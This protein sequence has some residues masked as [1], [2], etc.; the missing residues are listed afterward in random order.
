[1]KQDF[2]TEELQAE[3]ERSLGFRLKSLTRL[4]GA[5]A[6][7]FKAVRETDGYAF[8]VKCSPTSRKEAFEGLV[9]HLEELKG[10]KA[11]R[12]VFERETPATFRGYNVICLSW[13]QGKR[14]FPDQLSFEELIRFLD[15]YVAFS[16]AMQKTSRI[17]PCEP[18][19][20][21][22]TRSLEACHGIFGGWLRRILEE[23]LPESEVSYRKGR[24]SVV[25]GDFHHGN[26]LFAGGSVSGFFDL[27][28]FCFG[29]PTD[30]IIRYF[31]CAAE[32]LNFY[33]QHR[34]F[35]IL[36]RFEETVR[37]LPYS[38]MEWRVAIKGLLLRKIYGKVFPCGL[39]FWKAVDIA[40]RRCFYLKLLRIVTAADIPEGGMN[41]TRYPTGAVVYDIPYFVDTR[42]ALNVLEIARELPFGCQRIFYTYTVPEG[43]VRGVA[44]CHGRVAGLS[45]A[46]VA[47]GGAGR[48]H[49]SF[50]RLAAAPD[51]GDSRRPVRLP[52]GTSSG[53]AR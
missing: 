30:D 32:H 14:L 21:W 50:R 33:E 47:H 23:E 4:D 48:L 43:S 42:G 24:M 1:M 39:N 8:A 11:V 31:V 9:Q 53:D 25:H 45:G 26:F 28:E 40:Y 41:T 44:A 38:R 6:L 49:G 19:L 20:M 37:H 36:R 46:T 10:T 34:T 52:G 7:N 22:R 17:S 27:E 13:C 15:D 35:R 12:R 29:Y 18:T 3:L 16:A 2:T 5:S 51:R